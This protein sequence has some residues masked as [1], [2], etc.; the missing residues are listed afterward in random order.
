MKNQLRNFLGAVG[1]LTR[2]RVPDVALAR[3]L[4]E[5][6]HFFPAVGLLVG[7]IAAGV[8]TLAHLV[9]PVMPAIVLSMCATALATGGFHEDG[10]SDSADG[11]GGGWTKED[12]L[13]IMQ[14]SRIGS[15]GALTLILVLLLKAQTLAEIPDSHIALSMVNGHGLSRLVAVS[16]TYTHTYVRFEGKS[17][18]ISDG[19]SPRQLLF[20]A[21]TAWLPVMFLG[22]QIA[23][24]A[25]VALLI[26]R[27]YIG[28]RMTVRINGYTGDL[29]GLSQQISEVVFYL[30]V[31]AWMFTS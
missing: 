29:L 18:P 10:L 4:N 14:D 2:I 24:L 21:L 8:F 26:V 31:C 28:Y 16:F 22:W 30:V 1:F 19:I 3:P 15:F 11:L 6:S 5:T 9:L 25:F 23:V 27:T 20:A 13:R 7:S 12:V 17:K